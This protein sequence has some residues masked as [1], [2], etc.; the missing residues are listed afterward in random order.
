MHSFPAK[1]YVR[2][3]AEQIKHEGTAQKLDQFLT[4]SNQIGIKTENRNK[5]LISTSTDPLLWLLEKI[6]QGVP[7]RNFTTVC[8]FRVDPGQK[9]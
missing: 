9:K 2:F 6:C 7:P 8:L 4:K 3:D 5:Y 1:F